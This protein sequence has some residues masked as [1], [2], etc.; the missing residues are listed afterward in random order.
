MAFMRP[1]YDPDEIPHD[2]ERQVYIALRDQLP[3]D[4]I[5]LHSYPWLRPDREGIL[6]EG[7]ADFVVLHRDHGMLVLEVKG[8]ELRYHH[9]H[10]ER[11]HTTY[12]KPITDPFMQARKSMHYLVDRIESDSKGDVLRDDF[13]YGYAVVFPHDQ[14]DGLEPPGSDPVIIITRREMP[15]ISESI[16]SA[17]A[18]WPAR[19]QL[20]STHKW[21]RFTSAILPE[22][23]MY[24][25]IATSAEMLME[26]IQEMTDEQLDVLRGI[27]DDN[28][29]VYVTGVAGSGKT[30]IALERA[31][32]LA[33]SGLSTLFVC[34]NENLAEH[35]EARFKVSTYHV[36]CG[37]RL[38]IRHFHRLARE[39]I[40]D[41][42]IA[43]K[44]PEESVAREK[45]FIEDVPSMVE[46]AAYLLIDEDRDVQFD[47][48]V[49]DE[50]QDFHSRWW[51]VLQNTLLKSAEKGKF[52]AFGDPVQQLWQWAS[53][54][55]PIDL[56]T[57]FRLR[58]NCRNS[59]WIA[60]TS[61]RLADTEAEMFRRSP[62]GGKPQIDLVPSR[63]AMKGAVM[64]TVKRLMERESLSPSQ[65]A[66]IGPR[67][68]GNGSLA[69]LKQIEGVALTDSIK[70]WEAGNGI[71]VTTSRSFKGME[72]DVV[73]VYDLDDVSKVFTK[74]DLYVACTRARS[75]VHFLVSGK[76]LVQVIRDAIAN[77]QLE[78]Q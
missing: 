15:N 73:V 27:Y 30:Q 26:K 23:K 22:F 63:A 68:K 64:A 53:H 16:Q 28:D 20:M 40:I 60:K 29:R 59:R 50:A 34:F 24:R 61:L 37:D 70:S 52:Y 1:D 25:P 58:R 33:E 71:L 2:S 51:E 44:R 54:E 5:V 13:T 65:I 41:A 35:L 21:N 48:I 19:D 76:E 77:V 56:P 36:A 4:Y 3:N 49:M 17:M 47:A 55:P 69:N 46:Q 12:W 18:K 38:K 45:F 72:T 67:A 74:I 66:L 10:W 6:R 8:G 62:K 9:G 14:Y 43:W 11:S 7:E 31:V 75:H 42:S 78:L 32:R 57:R 39:M